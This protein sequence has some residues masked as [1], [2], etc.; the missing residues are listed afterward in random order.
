ML[1]VFLITILIIIGIPMVA[2]VIGRYASVGFFS[3]KEF[4]KNQNKKSKKN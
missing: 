2:Y 1:N 4:M 3:A